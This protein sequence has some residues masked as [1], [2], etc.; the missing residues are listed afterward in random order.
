MSR[1]LSGILCVSIF[2]SVAYAQNP[3]QKPADSDAPDV[4]ACLHL[5]ANVSFDTLHRA[6]STASK[7]FDRIGVHLRWSCDKR[8]ERTAA[9]RI[10]I[11]I[12]DR[13]PEY[14]LKRALAFSLPYARQGIRVFVFYD[15]MEGLIQ[16]RADCAGTILGHTLA[17]EIGHVLSR[18][19]SHAN[20]GLMRANWDDDD[21]SAMRMHFLSFTETEARIIRNNLTPKPEP[22]LSPGLVA[23]R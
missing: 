20:A 10:S 11:R 14:Y 8:Q 5:D 3:A 15:R 19:D 9:E 7:I 4:I 12:Q 18:E 1:F 23:Q 13:T 6:E 17:H 22:E 16:T 2:G 21:F